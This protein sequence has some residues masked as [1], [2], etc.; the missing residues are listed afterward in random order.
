MSVLAIV[1]LLVVLGLR[2]V[3]NER[4]RRMRLE[5]ERLPA[6]WLRLRTWLDATLV[7][8]GLAVLPALISRPGG[9]ILATVHDSLALLAWPLGLLALLA[10]AMAARTL[11]EDVAVYMDRAEKK[12][13][14]QEAVQH[15]KQLNQTPRSLRQLIEENFPD[16]DCDYDVDTIHGKANLLIRTPHAVHP[17]YI[18]PEE[19]AEK[20][21]PHALP[22]AAAVG[23]DLETRAI[24]WV[25]RQ[26]DRPP[27]HNGEHG[28]F[29][30]QGSMEGLHRLV[31][32]I[33]RIERRRHERAEARR[34]RR[35]REARAQSSRSRREHSRYAW[36]RFAEQAPLHPT[37][38]RTVA[39]RAGH[40]C[41]VCNERIESQD[42]VVF[43]T[44][45]DHSCSNSDSRL[46]TPAGPQYQE[47]VEMPDCSQCHYDFPEKFEGCLSRMR[48][49]HEQCWL[50]RYEAG[51]LPIQGTAADE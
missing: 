5:G 33:E 48:P 23:R 34:Q 7:C 26:Q 41:A 22:R 30:L 2:V 44:D 1:L 37:V 11:Y 38:R 8:G 3:L 50:R 46:L 31:E 19:Q 29:V 14:Q 18:L 36:K 24:L 35:E 12:R 21:L 27:R 40:R 28:V 42:L 32:R 47:R 49:A 25:P 10:L 17:V 20:G 9:W 43:I 16:L 45:P 13:E 4:L 39:H 6:R 15:G 51:G